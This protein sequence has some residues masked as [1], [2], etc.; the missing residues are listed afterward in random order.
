MMLKPKHR[1][2][3][4]DTKGAT[5]GS[6]NT[7][8][9][10][11]SQ[12]EEELIRESLNGNQTALDQLFG[13]YSRT[14]YPTALKLM[15]N[16]EDAEDALQDGLLSAF[17]NLRRFEGRSQFSTW[18]TRIVINAALMR[19]RSKRAHAAVSIDAEPSVDGD[20][21]APAERIAD[22]ARG[23]E[24]LYAQEEVHEIFARQLEELSPPLRSA[25]LLREVEGL[26]TEEAAQT[27]GVP[28]GTLK[29]QLHRARLQ[30]TSLLRTALGFDSEGSPRSLSAASL[31]C[32]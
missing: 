23:P 18:L 7:R 22:R 5:L 2:D 19:L 32:E 1:H 8:P 21:P 16:P 27:L 15:G 25:F 6:L 12:G 9:T 29:S 31:C 13:R 4:I 17:R 30:L 11:T 24:E 3:R 26:S 14:L 20:E 28:E 10:T